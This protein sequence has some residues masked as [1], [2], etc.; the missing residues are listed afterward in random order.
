MTGIESIHAGVRE[1]ADVEPVG[2]IHLERRAELVSVARRLRVILDGEVAG[3]LRQEEALT[4]TAAPG[5]HVLYVGAAGLWGRLAGSGSLAFH[6]GP[7]EI[8]AFRVVVHIGAWRNTFHIVPV[9][10][11]G[12]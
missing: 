5:H 1:P 3:W 11:P 4:I 9:L 10:L 8:A 2:V 12:L 7:G 6:L